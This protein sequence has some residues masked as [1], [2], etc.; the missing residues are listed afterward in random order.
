MTRLYIIEQHRDFDVKQVGET[1]A[2]ENC[3]TLF[4]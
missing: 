1:F 4:V 3:I 2:G